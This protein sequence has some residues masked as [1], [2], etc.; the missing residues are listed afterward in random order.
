VVLLQAGPQYSP[1]AS[2][3]VPED[4]V[5]SPPQAAIA[6]ANEPATSRLIVLLFIFVSSFRWTAN[7]L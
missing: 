7:F 4:P 3:L 1:L 6:P 2:S 5:E